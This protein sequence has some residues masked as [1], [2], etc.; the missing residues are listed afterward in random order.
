M[1]SCI[2]F[3]A[4]F[5]GFT[6][7]K[8]SCSSFQCI[9]RF[10]LHYIYTYLEHFPRNFPPPFFHSHISKPFLP[11]EASELKFVNI[12]IQLQFVQL[13][14]LKKKFIIILSPFYYN[15][16]IS[17]HIIEAC[18]I[19]IN[20]RVKFPYSKTHNLSKKRRKFW[21]KF[22]W[23]LSIPNIRILLAQWKYL[24][25]FYKLFK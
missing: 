24:I 11:Q 17:E 23:Y 25:D 5:P 13:E 9:S 15:T 14:I 22:S 2:I 8:V 16:C 20:V 3:Y 19:N 12:A 4:P 7:P 21:W 18:K 1:Y 10:S 6:D